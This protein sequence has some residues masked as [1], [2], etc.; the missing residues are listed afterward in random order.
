M[1]VCGQCIARVWHGREIGGKDIRASRLA[2]CWELVLRVIQRKIVKPVV[3]LLRIGAT[4]EKLAWSLA[5]GA[6]VG[7]NPLLGS[8]TVM[9]LALAGLLRLNVIASQISNHA[10]YPFELL[11]FPLWIKL[12]TL[13][14]GTEGLPLGKEE[15]LGAVRHHPWAT[16]RMLWMWEW[17]ALIV[18]LA[19]SLLAVPV[20]A[21]VLRPVLRHALERLH[22]EPV[23]EE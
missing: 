6:A 1:A 12:G 8:T 7:L 16:T 14:F 4:P 22:N 3:D 15:L 2:L 9:A 13:L 23:I 18:W 20:L 21:M 10:L 19:F 17:H 11:L 5:V